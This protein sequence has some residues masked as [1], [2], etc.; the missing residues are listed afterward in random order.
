MPDAKAKTWVRFFPPLYD[1]AFCG[2]WGKKNF[3]VE[4]VGKIKKKDFF[5]LQNH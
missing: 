1:V 3:I 5:L 2:T 4:F